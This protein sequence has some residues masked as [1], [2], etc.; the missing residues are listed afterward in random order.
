MFR[1]VIPAASGLLTPVLILIFYLWSKDALGAFLGMAEHYWPL[2]THLT[3]THETIGGLRRCI[4]LLKGYRRLGDLT[5]WLA[6]ASTASFAALY[7]LSLTRNQKQQVLMMIGLAVCYSIYPIFAGQF[8][9]YHW[10]LF[11]YFIIQISALCLA[12]RSG[13]ESD[14]KSVLLFMVLMITLVFGGL[15]IPPGLTDTF[16][17]VDVFDP[18][19]GG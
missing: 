17:G 2:Y 14:S 5:F 8:W 1:A 15:R 18:K 7:D 13:A 6:A 9:P 4:Y 11:L 16:R 3:G 12:D 10:L 19:G